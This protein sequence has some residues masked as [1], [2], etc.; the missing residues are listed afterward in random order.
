VPKEKAVEAGARGED[1][2]DCNS[3]RD[4]DQPQQHQR[5]SGRQRRTV[6]HEQRADDYRDR[7]QNRYIELDQPRAEQTAQIAEMPLNLE[8]SPPDGV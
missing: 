2:R 6:D 4:P 3:G 7:R 5:P 8:P 1:R